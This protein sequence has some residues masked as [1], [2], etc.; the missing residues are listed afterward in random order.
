MSN[1]KLDELFI[2]TPGGISLEHE[3]SEDELFEALN[4][5]RFVESYDLQDDDLTSY[6]DLAQSLGYSGNRSSD[7]SSIQASL[8]ARKEAKDRARDNFSKT[9]RE[10]VRSH[11]EESTKDIPVLGTAV[12]LWAKPSRV[13]DNSMSSSLDLA[14]GAMSG[15]AQQVAASGTQGTGAPGVFTEPGQAGEAAIQMK[16]LFDPIRDE[17]KSNIDPDLAETAFGKTVAVA[18]QIG[19]GLAVMVSNPAVAIAAFESIA[20]DDAVSEYDLHV[21]N[22][23]PEDRIK[24]GLSVA[25]PSAALDMLGGEATMARILAGANPTL[26]SQVYKRLLA[27]TIKEGVTE[28]AQHEIMTF[29]ANTEFDQDRERF[30]D[31]FM[32]NV[33]IG[34]VAAGG[35]GAGISLPQLRNIKIQETLNNENASK[36]VIDTMRETV[37]EEEFIAGTEDNA[38]H[39]ALMRAMYNGDPGARQAYLQILAAQETEQELKTGVDEGVQISKQGLVDLREAR[40]EF[41]TEEIPEVEKVSYRSEFES[42]AK[43]N[44]PEKALSIL[45][46][47]KKRG[48]PLSV[49]EHAAV[50]LKTTA[51]MNEHEKA[52]KQSFDLIES[53]DVE[54]AARATDIADDLSD[55][56]AEIENLAD[57]A[58]T[59]AGRA[60]GVG[61]AILKRE[62][63]SLSFS[64]QKAQ[65]L[66][67]EKLTNVEKK[68]ISDLIDKLEK[69][70][71]RLDKITRELDAEK[72]K[73]VH[74]V[75]TSKNISQKQKDEFIESATGESL[76]K[77]AVREHI[78]Q[79]KDKTKWEKAISISGAPRAL[80]ASADLSATFR[81]GGMLLPG[82]P[83]IAAQALEKSWKALFSEAKAEEVDL[84]LKS[85]PNWELAKMAELY[86][87]SLSRA[88]LKA[89]EENFVSEAADKVPWVQASNRQ[90]VTQLNFIRANVFDIGVAE[91]RK[92]GM[93]DKEMIPI[94]KKYAKF[95]NAASGRGSLGAFENAS[96]GLASVFF[97]PRWAVSRFEAPVRAAMM[98]NTP[99]AK[100]VAKDAGMF[101]GV[102]AALLTLASWAGASVEW[103]PDDSDFMKIKIGDTRIDITAGMLPAIRLVVN[104]GRDLASQVN[105]A[106]DPEGELRSQFGRWMLYKASP[107]INI[108]AEMIT[109]EDSIGNEINYVDFSNPTQ[110]MFVKNTVPLFL[111]DAW[112]AAVSDDPENAALTVPISLLGHGTQTFDK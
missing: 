40:Q 54:G 100:N 92:R 101:I 59:Q 58:R 79:F 23:D 55:Q 74:D 4:T 61:N 104:A 60:L 102:T 93:T 5:E 62:D 56:L 63:L 44:E 65:S 11:M 27:S 94:L 70:K 24:F 14:V 2:G 46:S 108:P 32:A 39:E 105:L 64:I 97:A 84:F 82:H 18:S 81:Q 31:E 50:A 69:M 110:N 77:K 21:K 75:L 83:A 38:A 6:E 90:M 66:K 8:K 73:N 13:F 80:I 10:I 33:L 78:Q 12:K 91:L 29:M 1:E 57:L 76:A 9:K 45:Q 35:I 112:E 28:G 16:A 3:V 96:R 68:A 36:E 37:T 53:G 42:V 86:H 25:L 89:R 109:G 30:G 52:V 111:Q 103:N 48:S 98:M 17:V 71:A 88:E 20:F 19:T 49:R 95:I 15:L 26:R 34:M 41:I 51:L 99:L 106:D 85:R 43:T 107:I 67:G 7:F 87:G 47:A 22:P 72:A